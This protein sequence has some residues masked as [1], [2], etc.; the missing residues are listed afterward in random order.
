MK[1]IL[2]QDVESLGKAR[3]IVEVKPGFA[4]NYLVKKGL[5]LQASSKNMEKLNE[6]LVRIA[7]ENKKL[8][9]AALDTHAKLHEKTVKISQ[10]AGP[11]GK[12][13][14]AVTPKDVAEAIK[15]QL[16]VELDRRKIAME[17]IKQAGTY[18]VAVKLH[19]DVEAEIYIIIANK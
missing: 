15:G 3:D 16:E 9:D 4:N 7:A 19:A 2:T 8:K 12:L 1:V 18:T 11:D 10:S 13:Y 6:D 14:G 17:P 5:A